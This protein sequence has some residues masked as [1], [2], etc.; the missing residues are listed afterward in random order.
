M[1][2]VV[3]KVMAGGNADDRVDQTC[4][5]VRDAY[6]HPYTFV[7]EMT[8]VVVVVVVVVVRE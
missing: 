4:D 8:V 5:C 6:E 7:V 1:K 2:V 3:V